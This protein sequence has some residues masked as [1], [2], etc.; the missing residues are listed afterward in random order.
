M[1][2]LEFSEGYGNPDATLSIFD[3]VFVEADSETHWREGVRTCTRA[4]GHAAVMSALQ[5]LAD[6]LSGIMF[7][8]SAAR[9]SD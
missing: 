4:H 1:F 7:Y 8:S 5:R 6:R 2:Q 3:R 9:L